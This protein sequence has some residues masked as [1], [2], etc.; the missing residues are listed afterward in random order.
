M[1]E[2]GRGPMIG[3]MVMCGVLIDEKKESEL[4]ELGVKDSKLLTPAQREAMFARIQEI[5][6]NFEII[7]LSPKDID[8][9]LNDPNLN[10]NWLE[11]ETT[12]KILNKLKP[13]KSFIDCPSNNVPAYTEYLE[14]I[15][16]TKTKLVV[17]HK[18]DMKYPVAAAASILAKVTRDKEIEKLK[19]K[20][21]NTGSGY[22][23][24]PVTKEFLQQN[25][26]KCPE[27]FRKTWASYKKVVAQKSQKGLGDF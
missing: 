23:A 5:V 10:L 11:A 9:A 7:I 3:P 12:A 20:Y 25:W 26:N 19:K 18:A 13:D 16:E 2:A 27:I 1:D 21:G 8:D 4:V 17:E 15:L 22:P 24:D 14:N 6:D